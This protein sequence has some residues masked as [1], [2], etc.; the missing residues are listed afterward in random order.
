M[1][2]L[3]FVNSSQF[4]CRKYSQSLVS[5]RRIVGVNENIYKKIAVNQL[6]AFKQVYELNKQKID[7]FFSLKNPKEN[8]FA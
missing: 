1:G 8:F 4:I 3:R 2:L 6:L 7:S 5:Q